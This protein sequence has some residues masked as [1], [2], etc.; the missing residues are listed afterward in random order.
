MIQQL[1]VS[2][3][4]Q[5]ARSGESRAGNYKTFFW[6]GKI[7]EVIQAPFPPIFFRSLFLLRQ[8][9]ARKIWTNP[10]QLLPTDN[11]YQSPTKN[12]WMIPYPI[13]FH[14]QHHRYQSMTGMIKVLQSFLPYI[15]NPMYI[16]FSRYRKWYDTAGILW[17][18]INEQ[19]HNSFTLSSFPFIFD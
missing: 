4:P 10:W 12:D 8:G 6:Q 5:E 3:Y 17:W 13:P 1:F 7:K 16:M 15:P 11:N 9:K 14:Q 2:S 18:L 19:Y